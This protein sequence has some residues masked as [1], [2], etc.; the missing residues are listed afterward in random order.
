[1]VPCQNYSAGR[2]SNVVLLGCNLAT[3]LCEIYRFWG[4]FS[5]P[6]TLLIAKAKPVDEGCMPHCLFVGQWHSGLLCKQ[7]EKQDPGSSW[8]QGLVCVC[9]SPWDWA[10]S[11]RRN[12][13]WWAHLSTGG[14][15]WLSLG[16]KDFLQSRQQEKQHLWLGYSWLPPSLVSAPFLEWNLAENKNHLSPFMSV[17]KHEKI[18]GQALGL[19]P[20]EPGQGT[21]GLAWGRGAEL[22]R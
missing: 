8:R 21:R 6:S 10:V 12:A 2:G 11:A 22:W 19:Y 1:M 9:R 15:A 18:T 13:F 4:W 20:G 14:S 3:Q 17:I 16:L 5:S 7:Q